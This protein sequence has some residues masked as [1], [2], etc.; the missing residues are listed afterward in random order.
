MLEAQHT[1]QR[2]Q[3]ISAMQLV[4]DKYNYESPPGVNLP[5]LLRYVCQSC[6][7]KNVDKH[8]C[9]ARLLIHDLGDSKENTDSTLD[10]VCK[11]FEGGM[12]GSR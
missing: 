2:A 12:Y 7:R 6:R 1:G 8:R 4:L 3:A 9:T 5:A 11:L 10:T